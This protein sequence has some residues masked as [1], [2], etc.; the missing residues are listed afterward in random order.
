MNRQE[1]VLLLKEM[2]TV[3]GSFN[4]A[5]AVSIEKDHKNNSW[6][7]HVNCVPHQSEV[8]CLEKIVASH[9]FEMATINGRTVF[10]TKK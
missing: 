6:E 5:Q 7:L 4:D 10:R 3:C 1:A 2:A 9:G 8:A